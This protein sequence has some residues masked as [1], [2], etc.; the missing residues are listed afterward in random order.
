MQMKIKCSFFL[1]IGFG[2]L[3]VN[4]FATS[5]IKASRKLT[6]KQ[7]INTAFENSPYLKA[8]ESERE[9]GQTYRDEAKGYRLP[10]V[11]ISEVYIRTN[12]PADVFGL[13]L[14]QEKFSMADF[15]MTDAN[16]P[17]PIDDYVTQ[18]QIS[19]P[20][21]M[22]GKIKH[23][24]LAG[25][26]MAAASEKKLERARQEVLFQTTKAYLDVL[27]AEKYVKVMNSVVFT[28]QKHVESAQAYFDTG[29]IMEADLLQAKVFL[30]Q[31][32]QLRIT[33]N[34]NAR[35]SIAFLANVMGEDQKQTYELTDVFTYQPQSYELSQLIQSGLE[36][37]PDLKEMQLKV[38]AAEQK[39]GIEKAGYKPK[40]F[41]VGQLN[42]HDSTLGGFEGDSYKVMA[43]AKYNLFNGKR[44]RAKVSRARSQYE[45]YNNY[46][47]QMENGIQL[48]IK[49]ALFRLQEAE[50]RYKVATL[51]CK[52]AK[53]NAKLREERYKKGVE[54]TTDLLDADTALQ[55][56]A[57]NKLHALFDCLKA[58][59][60]I[61]Y[62]IGKNQ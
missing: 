31:M 11:D 53:E 30:G 29:F 41:L 25:E 37:R 9:A 59:K 32:E 36:N 58:E 56:A 62:M 49:Q 38:A 44:T 61:K 48:Q 39:I 16:H 3:A 35:L 14:S 34:N 22:G 12:S 7:A 50:Q 13:Q 27:L 40:V 17:S 26:K 10:Q 60:N 1:I 8:I 19:Q 52:Q 5:P 6:L 28:V 2:V 43:V 57:T 55:K 20:L 15:A 4:T 54:K 47:T 33:A 23:G 45:S 18:L 46:L 42:Y 21:Y 51:S 24:I